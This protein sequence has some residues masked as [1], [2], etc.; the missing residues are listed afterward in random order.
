MTE[1]PPPFPAAYRGYLP[2]V[3]GKCRRLLGEVAAAEDIANES[4]LRLWQSG[5]STRASDPD[6]TRVTMAWLYRTCTR[7]CID[8]LRRRRFDSFDEES[9]LLP[10]AAHLEEAVHARRIV[11]QLAARVPSDELAVAVLCRIDGL[12]QPEA[13]EVLGISE[14][15][16]RRLLERFDAHTREWREEYVS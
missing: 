3:R 13:A 7:L 11:V 1:S 10:C 6:A 14:R 16:V 8:V 15:T 12:A 2:A 9:P 4:F 5:P